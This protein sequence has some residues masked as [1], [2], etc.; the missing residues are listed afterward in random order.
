LTDKYSGA[1][2][3]QTQEFEEYSVESS[4]DFYEQGVKHL[5]TFGYELERCIYVKGLHKVFVK[6]T[7]APIDGVNYPKAFKVRRLI[8]SEDFIDLGNTI[9]SISDE[10]VRAFWQPLFMGDPRNNSALKRYT[11]LLM[12][13]EV[14][15]RKT[16]TSKPWELG[17]SYNADGVPK[18]WTPKREWFSPALHDVT[19]KDIL[20][21]FPDAERR[22]LMLILGRLVVGRTNSVQEG[23][24]EVIKHTSRMAA[25]I[26]GLDAGLGK[27]TLFDMLDS[28]LSKVGYLKSQLPNSGRFNWGSAIQAPWTYRDDTTEK[29]LKAILSSEKIKTIITNGWMSVEEK[30]VNAIEQPSHSVLFLNTNSY[31]PNLVYQLDS[32]II[33]RLKFIATY[34]RPEMENAPPTLTGVSAGS[35]DARPF[36]HIP[37]LAGKLNVSEDALMLWLCRLAADL[38]IEVIN[39]T[40]DPTVNALEKAVRETS[41]DLRRGYSKELN[42]QILVYFNF[43]FNFPAT[44][45][46]PIPFHKVPWGALFAR[47]SHLKGHEVD[48]VLRSHW[49]STGKPAL[50]PWMGYSRLN[51]NTIEQAQ[52]RW[53]IEDTPASQLTLAQKY[54]YVFDA[55]FLQTGMPMSSSLVWLTE[56]WEYINSIKSELDKLNTHLRDLCQDLPDRIL[57]EI[58]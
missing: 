43:L 37:W 25:V 33:D 11:E 45:R 17:N 41:A 22:I 20:T 50:H 42:V 14:S 38:F 32:G 36:A 52:Q 39:D 6:T 23:T 29:G 56:Y 55:I 53:R 13:A 35:P 46:K 8:G 34:S 54:K 3:P 28:A 26:V 16:N 7:P 4:A 44:V 48:K 27:S 31:D 5:A 2:D 51:L 18:S 30:G 21:L 24:N 47:A 12:E 58:V 40:S 10:K 49:E 57:D 15:E 19:D 1:T 9:M